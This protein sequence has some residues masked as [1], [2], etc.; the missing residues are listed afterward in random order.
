MGQRATNSYRLAR[1]A[2][3]VFLNSKDIEAVHEF[4]E[5]SGATP[6]GRFLQRNVADAETRELL[7]LRPELCEPLIDLRALSEL[8]QNT[9]G[10]V[11]GRH[12]LLHDLRDQTPPREFDDADVGYVMRRYR[13]THDVWHCLLDLGVEGHDEVLLAAF[14]FGQLRLPVAGMIAS[15]GAL[16]HLVF[17]ARWQTVRLCWFQSYVMGRSCRPLLPA[18]WE[19]MWNDPIDSVRE[20]YGVSPVTQH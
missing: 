11:Y 9:L 8:P 16:K 3:R 13:Q 7:R 20:R 12:M 4:A 10:G 15:F 6:F 5:I 18:H 17:E 14:S 19:T 1:A 2:T